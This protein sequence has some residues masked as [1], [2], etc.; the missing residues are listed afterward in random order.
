[1]IQQFYVAPAERNWPSISEA[2]VKF[3]RSDQSRAKGCVQSLETR[4]TQ[5]GPLQAAPPA[6]IV[7]PDSMR[8]DGNMLHMQEHLFVRQQ[9]GKGEQFQLK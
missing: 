1:M 7:K 3:N 2:H 4:E 6:T 8:R 5:S 9:K